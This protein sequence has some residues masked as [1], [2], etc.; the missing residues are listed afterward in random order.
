M[1]C[2]DTDRVRFEKCVHF[3]RK[4]QQT[5]FFIFFNLRMNASFASEEFV[6]PDTGPTKI[7]PVDGEGEGDRFFC[8]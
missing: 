4:T 5:Y 1:K 3:V 8:E 6:L 7:L 2:N